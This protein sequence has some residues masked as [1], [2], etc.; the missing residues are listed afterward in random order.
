MEIERKSRRT[1]SNVLKRRE[2]DARASAALQ[3]AR[4]EARVRADAAKLYYAEAGRRHAEA[5]ARQQREEVEQAREARRTGAFFVPAQPRYFFVIRLKG[6]NKVPPKERKILRLLRLRQVHAGVLVRNSKAALSMLR[7]VEPYVTYGCPSR[8]SLARLVYK[9]GYGRVGEQRIPLT[10]NRVVEA[11]LGAVGI[12]C[13]EDLVNELWSCGP[14]FKRA[15]AFLWPFRLDSPRG[16][17][18][19]KRHQ[20]LAGGDQGPREDMINA[21][22]KAM[23]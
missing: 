3:G 11:E 5:H 19:A 20:Y 15:N 2:M 4:A 18:R 1:P 14:N 16:G 17:L 9:R 10:D 6:L 7:R 23:L 13:V 8:A 22:I 21:L 12:R